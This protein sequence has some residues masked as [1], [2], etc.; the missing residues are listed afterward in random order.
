M[1]EFLWP[2][3]AISLPLPLLARRL[4]PPAEIGQ[5]ALQVPFFA[6]IRA[7]VSGRSGAPRARRELLAWLAWLALVAAAARP[8]WLGEELEV[9]ISGRD[10]LLAIDLSGSMEERDFVLDGRGIRRLDALKAVAGP[11][12]RRRDGDRIGLILFGDRAYVQTPLTFD[13]ATVETMLMESEI[14]FA[15]R[16][17]AIG[18]AIGL[19]VKRMQQTKSDDEKVLILLSDGANTAG[20]VAPIKAGELAAQA[21]LKIYTIGMASEHPNARAVFGTRRRRSSSDLDERSLKEIAEKTGGRYFRASDTN[22]LEQVYRA[23]DEL[24][25]AIKDTRRYRPRTAL[26]MWPLG[27]ALCISFLPALRRIIPARLLSKPN[28]MQQWT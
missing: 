3:M 28:W 2:W 10:L 5:A 14:G 17:T 23:L 18:D 15:G 8:V 22:A 21:G 16:K 9:P 6:N 24:E 13:R 26:F 25:P 11:F 12:I 19:A 4:L 27:L 1:F 20:E 7:P